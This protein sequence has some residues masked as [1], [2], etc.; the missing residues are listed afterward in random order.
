VALVLYGC[1]GKLNKYNTREEHRLRVFEKKVL[2][3]IYYVIYVK[4]AYKCYDLYVLNVT[5]RVIYPRNA[6]VMSQRN[7]VIGGTPITEEFAAVR[8]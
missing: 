1:S 5:E 2:R 6:R 8:I 3:R 4:F 7:P